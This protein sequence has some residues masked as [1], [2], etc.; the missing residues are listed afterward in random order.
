MLPG[1]DLLVASGATRK[2]I[3]DRDTFVSLDEK[4][5]ELVSSANFS[6]SKVLRKG[7]VRFRVNDEKGKFEMIELKDILFLP[8]SSRILIKIS[9]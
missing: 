9:K 2:M 3:R 6:Y 5:K 1:E 8:E 4:F 7:E